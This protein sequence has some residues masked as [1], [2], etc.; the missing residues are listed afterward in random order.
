MPP[1]LVSRIRDKMIYGVLGHVPR[2]RPF[3]FGI[4]LSKTGTTSLNDALEVLGYKPFHLPPIA[5]VEA[6]QIVSQWPTWVYKYNALTDLTVA[7]LHRE[8]AQEFPNARFI[9]TRRDMASWLNSC[10]RHMSQELAD[11]RVVQKQTYLNDLS[12]A[13]YGSHIYNEASYRA[14]YERHE[15]D[16]MAQHSGNA[17][18]MDYDLIGGEGWEPLCAFLGKSTPSAPFPVA[19]KGRKDV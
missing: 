9:Y 7:V 13:F 12:D 5:H 10:R 18:F 19:N 14:A 16:V 2:Q 15:A 3:I 4:G 1:S 6:G 8:L 17:N 11:M